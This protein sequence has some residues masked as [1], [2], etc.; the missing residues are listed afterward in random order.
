MRRRSASLLAAVLLCLCGASQAA[1]LRTTR[2]SSP[3]AP[4]VQIDLGAAVVSSGKLDILTLSPQALVPS[5]LAP[6]LAVPQ[7]QPLAVAPALMPSVA[8]QPAPQAAF[9][10]RLVRIEKD[11]AA[12]LAAA[13]DGKSGTDS[14][15]DSGRKMEQVLTGQRDLPPAGES[16]LTDA[17]SDWLMGSL[18]QG[19]QPLLTEVGFRALVRNDAAAMAEIVPWLK[20][21]PNAL[22]TMLSSIYQALGRAVAAEG[23]SGPER[24]GLAQG[25][26]DRFADALAGLSRSPELSQ[27]QRNAIAEVH[28]RF[29]RG[30]AALN[31]LVHHRQAAGLFSS[32]QQKAVS[33]VAPSQQQ[34]YAEDRWTIQPPIPAAQRGTAPDQEARILLGTAETERNIKDWRFYMEKYLTRYRIALQNPRFSQRVR[35]QMTQVLS[36]FLGRFFQTEGALHSNLERVPRFSLHASFMDPWTITARA[37]RI[38]WVPNNA[39]L[40]LVPESGGYRVEA[41]FETDIQDDAVLK[42]VKASIEEYWNGHFE[43][44]GKSSSFRA[45]VSIR[46]LAAGAQFSEGSLR[47]MDSRNGISHALRDA[48]VLDRNL[49]YDVPAHEFGHILGLADE[50]REGYDPDLAAAVMLQNHASIMG[51]PNGKVLPRHFKTV[52]QLL[53]RRSLR[54]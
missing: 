26:N 44:G 39:N 3:V 15:Y 8:V 1:S 35:D 25:L 33:L 54:P 49:R 43:S 9:P 13:A 38:V 53:R 27:G 31:E 17:Q 41:D 32:L 40:R 45:V 4:S 23:L 29:L 51:S 48:I 5:F 28:G 6:A 16:G 7:I 30:Y 14:A 11:L 18:M 46:K 24:A 50:Y 2:L 42:T 52:S 20:D 19:P 21:T 34:D 36:N 37:H 12:P 22:P 10:Q 47:I